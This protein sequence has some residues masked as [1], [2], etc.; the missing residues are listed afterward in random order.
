V[1]YES[2]GQSVSVVINKNSIFLW[3]SQDG[4]IWTFSVRSFEASL[5]ELTVHV[6]YEGFAEG[7]CASLLTLFIVFV[8]ALMYL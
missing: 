2:F 5:P 7:W 6:N 8:V 3:I 1:R 4:E